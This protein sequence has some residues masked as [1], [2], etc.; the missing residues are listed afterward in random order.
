MKKKNR[1]LALKKETISRLQGAE[2]TSIKGGTKTRPKDTCK[3]N[4]DESCS[5]VGNCCPPPEKAYNE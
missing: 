2:L 4:T 1:R 5:A 3:C